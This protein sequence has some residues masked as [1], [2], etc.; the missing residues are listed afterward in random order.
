MHWGLKDTGENIF[1]R[2]S[3]LNYH[4]K[5][6][7]SRGSGNYLR[8]LWLRDLSHSFSST[9]GTSRNLPRILKNCLKLFR[10]TIN[11]ALMFPSQYWFEDFFFIH[12]SSKLFHSQRKGLKTD[13]F[14]TRYRT[15][16]SAFY[17]CFFF[18]N[19]KLS[20]WII[21]S[22]T[23]EWQVKVDEKSFSDKKK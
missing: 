13:F 14:R 7:D 20:Q 19:S 1:Q 22:F 18:V 8:W 5:K 21:L 23:F 12:S 15:A 3:A 16:K 4:V 11:I 10:L 2:R 17:F 9:S 6:K